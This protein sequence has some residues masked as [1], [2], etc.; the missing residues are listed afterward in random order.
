VECTRQ[1]PLLVRLRAWKLVVDTRSSPRVPT[2]PHHS[3]GENDWVANTSES[4]SVSPWLASLSGSGSSI[5]GANL[6][7]VVEVH[8]VRGY[9]LQISNCSR[10]AGFVTEGG[11]HPS[12]RLALQRAFHALTGRCPSGE[13][14]FFPTLRRHPEYAVTPF[15]QLQ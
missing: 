10:L 15:H 14:T 12:A 8:R 1:L 7:E 6:F 4:R 13:P 2:Q 3:P 9:R 11:E 5:A